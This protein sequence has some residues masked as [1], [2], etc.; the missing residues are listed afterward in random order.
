MSRR[1]RSD[2][3]D[4]SDVSDQSDVGS[5]KP[6]ESLPDPASAKLLDGLF[7]PVIHVDASAIVF[8]YSDLL[9]G[10]ARL[11]AGAVES[12]QR[13]FSTGR[14]LARRLL[15]EMSVTDFELLRDDDRVP[16]WP[17]GIV[18]SISHTGNLCAVAVAAESV[19]RGIGIDVEPDEPVSEGIEQRVCTPPEIAWLDRGPMTDRGHR[20]RMIFS[21]KEAVYKAFYPRLREFWGFQDVN[22]TLDLRSQTFTA[23]PPVSSGAAPVEG[24]ILRRAGWIIAGLAVR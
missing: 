5:R 7:E 10:E 21:V 17:A 8:R 3:S 11:V 9:K 4:R 16:K 22:V 23:R 24:R 14:V 13:E 1:D 2:Q 20:C 6:E 12:R 18:G 15:H 19:C